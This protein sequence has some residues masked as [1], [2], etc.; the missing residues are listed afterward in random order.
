MFLRRR[1]PI[2]SGCAENATIELCWKA[3]RLCREAEIARRDFSNSAEPHG[4]ARDSGA[5]HPRCDWRQEDWE[6]S[7]AKAPIAASD[8]RD[9]KKF[10]L[11]SI[12]IS[13]PQVVKREQTNAP[14]LRCR[15]LAARS[16]E[17]DEDQATERE[18]KHEQGKF[19][20]TVLIIGNPISLRLGFAA[21]KFPARDTFPACAS[22]GRRLR[23][24]LNLRAGFETAFGNSDIF[25][26]PKRARFGC[27]PRWSRLAP[28]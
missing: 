8:R 14:R 19:R 4:L 11:A 28:D 7:S 9:Y 13:Q 16:A 22:R 17:A 21:E 27:R 18:K 24:G 10:P 12:S 20:T 6:S 23:G 3:H 26:D 2:A 1:C 25:V 15:L 5:G